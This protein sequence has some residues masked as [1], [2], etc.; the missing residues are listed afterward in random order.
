MQYNKRNPHRQHSASPVDFGPLMVRRYKH[1][2]RRGHA[3][4][5]VNSETH[6]NFSPFPSNAGTATGRPARNSTSLSAQ[7]PFVAEAPAASRRSASRLTQSSFEL[8]H[9]L[10]PSLFS[11]ISQQS[12]IVQG[13]GLLLRRNSTHDISRLQKGPEPFRRGF[14][15]KHFDGLSVFELVSLSLAYSLT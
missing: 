14:R 2:I 3:N 4:F 8:E 11:M 7:G 15:W 5:I 12:A 9:C 13:P 6:S 1:Q 10:L